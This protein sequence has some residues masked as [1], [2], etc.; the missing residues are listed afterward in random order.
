[1]EQFTK[2]LKSCFQQHWDFFPDDEQRAEWINGLLDDYPNHWKAKP[3]SPDLLRRNPPP[4]LA[5]LGE[6][7]TE[8]FCQLPKTRTFT[9]KDLCDTQMAVLSHSE[10]RCMHLAKEAS[11][12]VPHIL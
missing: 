5:Q 2:H 6:P 12:I 7:R 10:P 1:V 3:G 11:L 8:L 4:Y 9:L